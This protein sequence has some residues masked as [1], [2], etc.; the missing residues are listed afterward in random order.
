ML[1]RTVATSTSRWFSPKKETVRER[2]LWS[3]L[4]PLP[5]GGEVLQSGWM[6]CR[7]GLQAGAPSV[8][9]C[10][11]VPQASARSQ[12][13]SEGTA[14]PCPTQ[15][16]PLEAARPS[17]LKQLRFLPHRVPGARGLCHQWLSSPGPKQN[18]HPRSG[19]KGNHHWCD[20]MPGGD[21]P[22]DGLPGE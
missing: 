12:Q 19:P 21:K 17:H 13:T 5:R 11:A 4:R 6:G 15:I 9:F 18:L 22:Q 14:S 7:E 3:S 1:V 2:V 10:G 20:H 16:L 8:C